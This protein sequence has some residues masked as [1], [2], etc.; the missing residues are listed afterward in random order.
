M[1]CPSSSCPLRSQ[2]WFLTSR[3]AELELLGLVGEGWRSCI[4][5]AAARHGSAPLSSAAQCCPFDQLTPSG[6]INL[7]LEINCKTFIRKPREQE[8]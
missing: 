2:A 4:V 7:G 1:H 8:A 5:D 3:E 6:D